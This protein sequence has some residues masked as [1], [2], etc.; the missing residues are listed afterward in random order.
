MSLFSFTDKVRSYVLICSIYYHMHTQL[1][2]VRLANAVILNFVTHECVFRVLLLL[3][4]I[5]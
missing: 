5:Y 4:L 2:C 3:E 1:Y